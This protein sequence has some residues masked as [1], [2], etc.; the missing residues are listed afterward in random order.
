MVNYFVL[1][2]AKTLETEILDFPSS[3]KVGQS[4][5]DSK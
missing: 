1:R 2:P 4:V 5:D 3:W